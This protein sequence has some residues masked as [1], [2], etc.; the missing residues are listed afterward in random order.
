MKPPSGM[1]DI[2][3]HLERAADALPDRVYDKDGNL[4]SSPSSASAEPDVSD[5]DADTRTE[6][7]EAD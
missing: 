7:S 3:A 1:T 6:E 4:I 2:A 5:T